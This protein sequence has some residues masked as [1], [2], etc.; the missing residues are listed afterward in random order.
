M[1]KH[2]KLGKDGEEAAVDFLRNKGYKIMATNWRYRKYELDIIAE[3]N[4]MLVVVEVKSRSGTFFEQPFQAVTKKKQRFIISATNEYINK[5]EVDLETRF[6]IISIV[7]KGKAWNF[8][9]IEDAFYPL[10]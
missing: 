7:A 4:D 2:N 8:E 10:A 3:H 1:S 6:D 9:H 5:F